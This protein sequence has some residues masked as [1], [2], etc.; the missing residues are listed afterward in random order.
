MQQVLWRIPIKVGSPE[1]FTPPAWPAWNGEGP[2]GGPLVLRGEQGLGDHLM[3]SSLAAVLAKSNG[4][5]VH[6]QRALAPG[7]IF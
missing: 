5:G 6:L 3:F 1:G 4:P 2:E 7:P